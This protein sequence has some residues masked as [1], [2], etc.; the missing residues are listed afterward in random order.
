VNLQINRIQHIGIPVTDIARSRI[1][2]SSLGFTCAMK[3]SFLHNG[4]E[5]KV[6]MMKY[7]DIIIELYQL[8]DPVG[9]KK[10][11]LSIP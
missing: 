6:V 9:D 1:F 5:G 11:A 8:P 2:Y 10:T 4:R 3:N 7:G